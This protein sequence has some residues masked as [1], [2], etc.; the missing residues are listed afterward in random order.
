VQALLADD[1]AVGEAD[2]AGSVA[3]LG[4]WR[5]TDRTDVFEIPLR[6]ANR[7]RIAWSS[8]NR[9]PL[10]LSYQI[11]D[12]KGTVLDPEGARIRLPVPVLPGKNLTLTV[13]VDLHICRHLARPAAVSFTVVQ[14][15]VDWWRPSDHW[16]P[17]V[18][19]LPEGMTS[20]F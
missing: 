7:G 8:E 1:F 6:I 2:R 4:P 5:E 14:E 13:G 16:V 17:A 20:W 12:R 9:R 3:A 10:L 19:P 15:T 11:L 18:V